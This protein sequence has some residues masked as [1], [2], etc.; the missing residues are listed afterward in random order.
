M[1]T[2]GDGVHVN[3]R[4]YWYNSEH[5][6][7]GSNHQYLMYD[8]SDVKVKG[9]LVVTTGSYDGEMYIDTGTSGS[10]GKMFIGKY[11]G[12]IPV[13][14]SDAISRYATGSDGS[15]VD[16]G[17]TTV[18]E[19]GNTTLISTGDGIHVDNNNYWYTTG[20][21]KIGSTTNYLNWD[22]TGLSV[23]G[24]LTASG[25]IIPST[26]N[27]YDLGSDSAR[28]ANIYSADV[29]LSNDDTEGNEVD[30]TTGNWTIQEGNDDLFIINRKTGK[31]FKFL[32]QEVT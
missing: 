32:L 3:D 24:P 6:R 28:W 1:T 25:D 7:V 8:K 27:S 5:Y 15:I 18:D 12:G 13:S 17:F 2:T 30:G 26:H 14:G 10:M 9:Q 19:Y 21:F 23:T 31:K 16:V 29:H 20:H 11:T 4:N 22:N